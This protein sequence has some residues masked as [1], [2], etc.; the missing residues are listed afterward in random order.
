MI[1]YAAEKL[2]FFG[3]R[4]VVVTVIDDEYRLPLVAGQGIEDPVKSSA[5][6]QQKSAPI[7]G[8]CFEQVICRILSDISVFVDNNASEEIFTDE[9]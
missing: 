9:R 5:Y 4:P 3:T 8:A 2:D 6:N 1:E 7:V